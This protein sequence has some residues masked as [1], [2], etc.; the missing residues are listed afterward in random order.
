MTYRDGVI[1]G[2]I[3]TAVF[4]GLFGS[5]FWLTTRPAK[6]TT[7]PPIAPP[8]TVQ[9]PFKEE[10]V[11]TITLTPQAKDRLR[12]KTAVIKSE[13]IR[14]TRLLGGELMIPAG[15][16]AMV[17][18]PMNGV[19]QLAETGMPQIGRPIAAGKVVFLF[20]PLLT[21]E[22]K[23]QLA[24]TRIEVD[25]QAKAAE[26]NKKLAQ[27]ARDRAQ[28]VFESEAGSRRAVEEAEAQLDLAQR[29]LDA[30][31]ARRNLLD[32][33]LDE[34]DKGTAAAIP[35]EAP[36]NGVLRNISAL[37]GQRVPS[38]APLFEVADLSRLWV[39]V[40][41]YAGEFADIEAKESALVG[42]LNAKAETYR[43][44][45]PATAPPS[46]DPAAG[47]TD[48]FFD[49]PNQDEGLRPGERVA[50]RV[51]LHGEAKNLTVPWSAVVYDIHGGTWVY[52]Q[53]GENVFARR[54]VQIKS[55]VDA[56]AVLSHGPPEGTRV[57]VAGAQELFGTETGFTK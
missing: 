19:V 49:M 41:V 22:G 2:T 50:V 8:A 53:N 28:K 10:Q 7:T 56:T 17:Q 47:T 40:P 14:R 31:T 54:R 11:N 15:R 42:R 12:L 16:T 48:L 35:I 45:G 51:Y 4:A 46:A 9:Q 3:A 26:T 29:A 38:G 34:F 20:H 57:V 43:R 37:P 25:G 33:L 23:A 24:A 55:V 30:A 6:T 13:Q 18:A 44:A 36:T 27:Q 1:T 52:E 39:K 21:P 5:I 32:R